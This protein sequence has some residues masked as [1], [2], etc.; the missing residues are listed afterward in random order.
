MNINF[1]LLISKKFRHSGQLA[2]WLMSNFDAWFLSIC[3]IYFRKKSIIFDSVL[4]NCKIF[5]KDYEY[6][7][8][9]IDK[10]LE[11]PHWNLLC[12]RKNTHRVFIF[13]VGTQ[14][15][16]ICFTTPYLSLSLFQSPSFSHS[17]TPP[18]ISLSDTLLIGW[19]VLN[20]N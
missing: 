20:G 17:L 19:I 5:Q 16:H 18:S 1:S 12:L 13:N 9:P 8:N 10:P 4:W 15:W 11:L 6:K 2:A 14:F 7:K 3:F